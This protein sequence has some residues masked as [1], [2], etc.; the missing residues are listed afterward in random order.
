V[1]VCIIIVSSFHQSSQSVKHHNDVAN[2]AEPEQLHLSRL[3]TWDASLLT[4]TCSSSESWRSANGKHSSLLFSA[5]LAIDHSQI[6]C[7][8]VGLCRNQVV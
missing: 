4:E 6:T 8:L 2:Q 5:V 3:S 7:C 1:L